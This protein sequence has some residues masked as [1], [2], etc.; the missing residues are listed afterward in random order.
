VVFGVNVCVCVCAYGV[1]SA[2]AKSVQ[3][4]S[5]ET[6]NSVSLPAN[7]AVHPFVPLTLSLKPSFFI[8]VTDILRLILPFFSISWL[9]CFLR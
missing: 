8:K 3:Q 7:L 6:H 1:E 4:R 5:V 2:G 9:P